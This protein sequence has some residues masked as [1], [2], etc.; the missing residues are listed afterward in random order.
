MVAEKD[1]ARILIETRAAANITRLGCEILGEL[2]AH[3][4]RLGLPVATLHVRDYAFER[5][6]AHVF[7]A[8]VAQVVKTNALLAAAVQDDLSHTLGQFPEWGVEIEF[9]VAGKRRNEL[10]VIGVTTIPAADSAARK[11]QLVVVNDPGGIEE[12]AHAESVASA[13]G[14]GGI[15]EREHARLQLGEAVAAKRAGKA[16]REQQLLVRRVIHPSDPRAAVT[17]RQCGF[18]RLGETQGLVATD[19]ESVHHRLDGV[20]APAIEL[21]DPVE[22]DHFPIDARA[23]VALGSQAVEDLRVLALAPLHD[24]CEQHEPRALGQCQHLV[25]HLADGLGLE[26]DAVS[27]AARLAGAGEQQAQVVVDLGDRADRGAR[28]VRGR[29]LLDGDGR[30]QAL[31]VVD[32]GLLHHRQ[33]LPRVGRERLDV[34]PLAFGVDRVEGE[35][36]LARAGQP[37]DD[38]ELVARQIQIDALQIMGARAANTDVF[39]ALQGP[40]PR[41]TDGRPGVR[42]EPTGNI[43]NSPPRD[44]G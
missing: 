17:E 42:R 6:L 30:R 40:V 9:V 3:D 23:Y 20:L 25:D 34:A 36:R 38:D 41:S 15:V 39:H 18:E 32:V 21:F 24:R 10:K 2:L 19:L 5:M 27:G 16:R 37:G 4:A 33:E 31:D 13:A 22:L 44:R 12:R 14:T 11:A 26:R 28:V 43:K 1:I 7:V 35:R 8:P 29:L